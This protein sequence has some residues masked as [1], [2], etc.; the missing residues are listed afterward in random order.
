MKIKK[1]KYHE[2]NE[3]NKFLE[4]SEIKVIRIKFLT[5]KRTDKT[6]E[7]F[8]ATTVIVYKEMDYSVW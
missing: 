6:Q 3:L 7:E 4:N 2:E 8:I 5:A 1:F